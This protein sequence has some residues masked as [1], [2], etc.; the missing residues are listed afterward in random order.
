MLVEY[1][2]NVK[3]WNVYGIIPKSVYEKRAKLMQYREGE[4]RL[5]EK[6]RKAE[7][8]QAHE[9][10]NAVFFISIPITKHNHN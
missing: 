7:G 2:I 1:G 4:R 6:K 9:H 10:I 5:Q 3:N 8:M